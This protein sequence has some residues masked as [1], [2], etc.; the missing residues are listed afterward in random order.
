[1]TPEEKEHQMMTALVARCLERRDISKLIEL[2]EKG[3]EIVV[4]HE[5]SRQ[6]LLKGLNHKLPWGS[7]D[8]GIKWERDKEIWFDMWFL[9]EHENISAAEAARQL[10]EKYFIEPKTIQ[11]IFT[12]MNK[13]KLLPKSV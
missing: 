4:K 2:L 3:R 8:G 5:G 11:D 13:K 7:G 1:M 9:K 6:L 10:H 12:R